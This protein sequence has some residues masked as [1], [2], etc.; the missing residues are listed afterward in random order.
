[1]AKATEL[2][3]AALRPAAVPVSAA[4]AAG[5]GAKRKTVNDTPLQLKWPA[6]DAIAVK[7]A[8]IDANETISELI[9]HATRE[10]LAKKGKAATK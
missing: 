4:R 9:L 2:N 1:M 5:D 3:K 10:Y 7:H 8:A 6:A